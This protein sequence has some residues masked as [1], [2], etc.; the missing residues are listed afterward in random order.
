MLYSFRIVSTLPLVKF[1]NIVFIGSIISIIKILFHCRDFFRF[2]SVSYNKQSYDNLSTGSW[3]L[4]NIGSSSDNQLDIS[5]G[6]F[7]KRLMPFIDVQIFK[8]I[9][10]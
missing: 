3:L 7:L 4:L 8:S 2:F 1:K 6:I 10:P 5:C 9:L